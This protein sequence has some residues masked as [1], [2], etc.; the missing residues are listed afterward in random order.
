M[1]WG[2]PTLLLIGVNRTN[3]RVYHIMVGNFNHVCHFSAFDNLDILRPTINMYWFKHSKMTQNILLNSLS[4]GI[5][6]V[7]DTGDPNA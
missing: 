2:F 6:P 5:K 4:Y 1:A 7:S 3:I